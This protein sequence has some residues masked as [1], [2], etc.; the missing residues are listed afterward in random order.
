[1]NPQR[2]ERVIGEERDSEGER[3]RHEIY[4]QDKQCVN[5]RGGK[6]HYLELEKRER[7]RDFGWM[8][9]NDV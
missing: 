5:E 6:K 3:V 1:M 2:E 8:H 4:P 7:E 9:C